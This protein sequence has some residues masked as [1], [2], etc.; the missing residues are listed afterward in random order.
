[1]HVDG[2]DD[3][4]RAPFETVFV[5]RLRIRPAEPEIEVELVGSAQQ[6]AAEAGGERN[7]LADRGDFVV[8]VVREPERIFRRPSSYLSLSA[9]L[10]LRSA[11]SPRACE[12]T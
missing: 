5:L 9:M 2:A 7:A 11:S 1:M 8:I 4:D 6:M 3:A 10:N 12:S